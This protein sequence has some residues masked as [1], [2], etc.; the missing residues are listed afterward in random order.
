MTTPIKDGGQSFG[1]AACP[2]C[3]SDAK[4]SELQEGIDRPTYWRV[5]CSNES[6]NPR[7]FT[8]RARNKEEAA[9]AWNKRGG[10]V[11][12]PVEAKASKPIKDGGPAFPLQ[13]H[14]SPGSEV[15]HGMSLRKYYIGQLI[16]G[17]AAGPFWNDNVQG[18]ERAKELRQI[19][20]KSAIATVDTLLEE[21]EKMTNTMPEAREVK[22]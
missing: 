16:A 19:F 11:L 12:T 13:E 3:G 18:G 20:A 22:P 1:L 15:C 6:C 9:L 10:N 7:P 21:T 5:E 17:M 2:F 14:V 4:L 8:Y